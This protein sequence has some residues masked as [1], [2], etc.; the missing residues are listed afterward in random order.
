MSDIDLLEA[1]TNSAMAEVESINAAAPD[2]V[3]AADET[4]EAPAE[5]ESEQ[6]ASPPTKAAPPK[7]AKTQKADA[8]EAED[9]EQS[10]LERLLS[11]ET[12][13]DE[14]LPEPTIEL[15]QEGE[16]LLEEV[17]QKY[18]NP[19]DILRHFVRQELSAQSGIS[20]WKEK[21]ARM[22]ELAKE[23]YT[24][25]HEPAWRPKAEREINDDLVA[26][27]DL[28][29]DGLTQWI[30]DNK[31]IY[32][33]LVKAQLDEYRDGH[34]KWRNDGLSK[35]SSEIEKVQSDLGKRNKERF[36]ALRQ[37]MDALAPET[38]GKPVLD[39]YAWDQLIREDESAPKND[40][41]RLV[42]AR[43]QLN[44]DLTVTLQNGDDL[45][46]SV[47]KEAL[48]LVVRDKKLAKALKA[49]FSPKSVEPAKAVR[50]VEKA[51]T[52]EIEEV[53]EAPPRKTRAG[54]TEDIM[55]RIDKMSYDLVRTGSS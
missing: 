4:T 51:T 25:F 17:R 22:A 40:K 16:L 30:D 1:M 39:R 48:R 5:A 32:D 47:K 6:E 33:R 38:E 34:E 3:D 7:A 23:Q 21:F 42:A 18:K 43:K 35:L 26:K 13:E 19:E 50:Q 41:Q 31:P 36:E 8:D 27:Y 10:E 54:S 11:D 12:D 49:F 14:S 46:D 20:T 53:R 15:D 55:D 44:K 29:R 28:D 9:D 45:D 2:A 52:A 37:R 24:E